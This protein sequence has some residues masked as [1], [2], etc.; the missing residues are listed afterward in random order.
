[1]LLSNGLLDSICSVQH[2]IVK[3]PC[4]EIFVSVF[5]S[6]FVPVFVYAVVFQPRQ[7]V[8]FKRIAGFNQHG[9]TLK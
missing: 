2:C 5:A 4:A 9:V 3:E 1:M 8:V 7:S 6:V